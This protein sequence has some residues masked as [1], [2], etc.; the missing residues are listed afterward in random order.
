MFTDKP[1]R[2]TSVGQ[3]RPPDTLC[4]GLET[5]VGVYALSYIQNDQRA[6]NKI[7]PN[8]LLRK[9]G[10]Q[11]PDFPFNFRNISSNFKSEHKPELCLII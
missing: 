2:L 5:G 4:L 11:L 9:P 8:P 7:P 10:D 3:A 6:Q 1:A